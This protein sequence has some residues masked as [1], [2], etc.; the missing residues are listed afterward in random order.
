[1]TQLKKGS[2]VNTA[3]VEVVKLSEHIGARIEGVFLAGGL[4]SAVAAAINDALLEHKVIFFRGQHHLDDDGHG[5]QHRL[6]RRVTLAGQLPISVT[7]KHSR[8]ITGRASAYTVIDDPT[9]DPS[10]P[11]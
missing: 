2:L 3:G 6:M 9:T 11:N 4:D 5:N 1:L 8:L 10:A 7:G